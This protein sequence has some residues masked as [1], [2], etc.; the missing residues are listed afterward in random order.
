MEPIKALTAI[1]YSSLFIASFTVL[2]GLKVIVS[3][4]EWMFDKLGLE[5]KWMRKKREEHDLLIQTSR[6]L[7]ELQKNYTEDMKRSDDNDSEI[8]QDIK[9]LTS[10]FIEKEIDDMRWEI[11]NFANKIADGK[12][13][14]KDSYQHCIKT[15]QK[16]EQILHDNGLENGEVEI[17]MELINDSYKEKLKHG[18]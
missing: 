18:F 17:S 16:Y 14:N 8:R 11:N 3:I 5:T 1:D 12:Q 2:V 15:Y 7:A 9:N 4:F 6:G 13:C 10:M